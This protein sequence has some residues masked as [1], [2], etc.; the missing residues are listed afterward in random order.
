MI[1]PGVEKTSK[2]D[3]LKRNM[4]S[5]LNEVCELYNTQPIAVLNS[6]K[7]RD[8]N[9]VL[10]RQITMYLTRKRFKLTYSL[11]EIGGYFKK[12][13]STVLHSIRAIDNLLETDRDFR[14]KM[15]HLV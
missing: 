5:V 15:N 2:M 7:K 14:I 6:T 4:N 3:N 11:S 1:L 10:S 8:R 12:D 9:L 13:H